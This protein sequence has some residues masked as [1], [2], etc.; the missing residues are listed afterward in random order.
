VA[1]FLTKFALFDERKMAPL[2]QNPLELIN[3]YRVLSHNKEFAK[4]IAGFGQWSA[5]M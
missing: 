1:N 2:R 5:V 4:K 3:K